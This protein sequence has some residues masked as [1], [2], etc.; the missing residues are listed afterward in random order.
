MLPSRLINKLRLHAGLSKVKFNN[1][2]NTAFVAM[3]NIE[4]FNKG[5]REY[6]LPEE[7]TFQSIDLYE[8]HKGTMLNVIN[9]LNKLGFKVII[10]L[11]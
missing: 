2:A 3:E 10:Y 6:G 7:Q 5:A 1:N 11:M 9:C 8:G 4:I